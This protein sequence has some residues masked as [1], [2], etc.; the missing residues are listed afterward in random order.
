MNTIQEKKYNAKRQLIQIKTVK[1]GIC[2]GNPISPLLAGIYLNKMDKYF[3]NLS[4]RKNIKY[5][6]YMDDIIVFSNN[7]LD[8]TIAKQKARF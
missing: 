3:D 8:L 2:R 1:K 4:S 5:M 7:Y 6:R